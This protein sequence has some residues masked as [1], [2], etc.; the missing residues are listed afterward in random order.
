VGVLVGVLG[1][2]G[3]IPVGPSGEVIDG[4][5]DQVSTDVAG[6]VSGEPNG[7]FDQAIIAVFDGGV[8]KLQGTVSAVGDLDVFA[9][10]P[11]ASGSR[12]L[13]DAR[14]GGAGIG[15]DV[16]VA[17][18]DAGYRLI[19]NNDDRD[20]GTLRTLDSYIDWIVRR[21]TLA[22][23]LVVTHSALARSD[24]FTGV[25]EIDLRVTPGSSV[26]QP[27]GQA[28]LLNFDGGLVSIGGRR[29]MTLQPFD[30]ADISP[31][32][33]GDTETIKAAIRAVFEQNFERFDVTILTSDDTLPDGVDVSTVYFG[34]YD[35]SAF[36]VADSVDLYNVD[37]CDDAIVFTESFEPYYFSRIPSATELGIAIGNVGSHEAGH[38]L[39]LNHVD[40]DA[41]LMDDQSHADAFIE[42]QEFM[43]A[44]LSTDIMPI[45]YQDAVLLLNDIVGP[46]LQPD[47]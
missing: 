36:G 11:L 45:G 20:D 22:S 43:Q 28:L 42:D 2:C 37:F 44:P 18:F 39:G 34:G 25:Y 13:L 27:V 4:N 7:S 41:A 23:Y 32:Y 31:V 21:D 29:A 19:Y 8:A 1:G 16:S 14:A 9:L 40:D 6:K 12:F 24:A 46:F 5:R 30:A 38:L 26:P 17:V 33:R 10:G 47:F 3:A 15:L 35:A